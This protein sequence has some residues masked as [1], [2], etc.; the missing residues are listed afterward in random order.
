MSQIFLDHLA[1]KYVAIGVTIWLLTFAAVVWRRPAQSKIPE[2]G[3]ESAEVLQDVVKKQW[4][5][6]RQ[7]IYRLRLPFRRI[8]VLPHKY[9][10]EY[11]WKPDNQ[12]SSNTDLQERLLG[13]WTYIGSLTPDDPGAC[14]LPSM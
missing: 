11:V 3:G 6:V 7:T 12:I 14:C 5:Q 8:Y 1:E 10:N 9:I 2:F 13:R 4:S